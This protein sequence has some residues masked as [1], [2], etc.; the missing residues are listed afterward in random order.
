MNKKKSVPLLLAAGLLALTGCTKEEDTYKEPLV[1]DVYD[2]LTDYKG[3]QAGWYAQILEEKFQLQLNFLDKSEE[4]SLEQA[5]IFVCSKDD[6][7]P[8]ELIS[9][10]YLLNLETLLEEGF[11]ENSELVDYRESY[12]YWNG[13]LKQEGVYVLPTQVSRLSK[14]TPSEENTPRYGMYLNWEAYENIN[15]P[16]IDDMEEFLDVMEEMQD[17]GETE[18][19]SPDGI[20]LYTDDDTD[21]LDHITLLMGA[22][23]GQREGFLINTEGRYEELLDKDSLYLDALDWLREAYNRGL[24]PEDSDKLSQEQ[25]L[26][27]YRNGQV[28]LSMEPQE[29][30]EGYEFAP[31]ED[32]KIVSYGC[33]PLGNL[34][35][36]VGISTDAEDP[37]RILEFIGW[38][39]STEGIMLSGTE[40]D[41]K[42]AGPQGLTW[43]MKDGNPILTE[44]GEQVFAKQIAVSFGG[45]KPEPVAMDVQMPTEW[46]GGTWQQGACKLNLQTVTTVEVSP[47]GFSYNYTLWNT[48]IDRFSNSDPSWQERMEALE[49]MEYLI[50]HNCLAIIPSYA[51]DVVG[52]S[53]GYPQE[54]VDKR[55]ECRQV[56]VDYSW[57]MIRAESEEQS[58]ELLKEMKAALSS[59]GYEDVLAYDRECIFL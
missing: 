40:T 28:L 7:S 11:M 5:D 14:L 8:K 4:D 25:V 38:L 50:D 17:A 23:G 12:E 58:R 3:M 18:G 22:L 35:Y 2:S 44:F 9:K 19:I 41:L 54:I 36:Y 15:M 29:D 52:K 32:M 13:H 27:R 56:I 51:P 6:V 45:T 31:V 21:L 55:A 57:Q 46:G 24:I 39:Y 48:T 47:S 33:N 37:E 1:I 20:L 16:G 34:E 53:H 59:V 26:E 10:G 49:P 42:A 30:V 43:E